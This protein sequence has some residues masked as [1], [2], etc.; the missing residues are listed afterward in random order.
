[1]R[2]V[3]AALFLPFLILTNGPYAKGQVWRQIV[4][5]KTTR[6]EVERLLG[7]T[8]GDYFAKY[9]LKEGSLFIEYSSGPCKPERKGGWKVPRDVVIRVNFSPKQRKRI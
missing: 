4:P 9:E 5:L 2:I 1:M 3:L 8:T 6:G 7:S